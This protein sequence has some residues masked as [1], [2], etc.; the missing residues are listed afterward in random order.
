MRALI[1]GLVTTL[2]A[3]AQ[4]PGIPAVPGLS[5]EPKNPDASTYALLSEVK[6]IAPG[7]KFSVALALTHQEGWHS[8]YK[9]PGGI[10]DSPSITWKLPAGFQAGEMQWPTP[11]VA[12]PAFQMDEANPEKAY[13]YS[14]SDGF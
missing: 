4:I 2:L 14:N 11:H 5:S 6:S 3:Q 12:D 9:N 7:Q 1:F 8:Y 10:E 13:T